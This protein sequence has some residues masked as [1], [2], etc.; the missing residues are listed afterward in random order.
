MTDRLTKEEFGCLIALM[1]SV[2]SEDPSTKVGSCI[3]DDNQRLRALGYNGIKAGKRYKKIYHTDRD[4][5]LA[6]SSHS[7]ENLL[8]LITR[9][10]GMKKIYLTTSPCASCARL[11]ACHGIEKVIFIN[12]YPRCDQYPLIFKEH[13]VKFRQITKKEKSRIYAEAS[14]MLNSLLEIPAPKV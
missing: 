8:S 1:A 5:R 11:I 2:R 13:G 3:E 12:K 9:N 14:K 10:D 4:A 6:A 7:E